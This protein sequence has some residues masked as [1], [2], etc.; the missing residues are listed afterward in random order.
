MQ[1]WFKDS[2]A[3]KNKLDTLVVP[4]RALLFSCDATSMYTNI[5]TDAAF[6]VIAAFLRQEDTQRKFEYNAEALIRALEIVMR[7]NIFRF[8]D[9]YIRQLSGTAMG[10]PCAPSWANIFQALWENQIVAL[11]AAFLPLYWRFLDDVLGLWIP[12]EDPAEDERKWQEFIALSQENYGLEWIFT[13]RGPSIDFMDLTITISGDRFKTSL[14]EKPMALYLYLPPHS[15]HAPGVR[16]GL[17]NGEIL[18][19]H[20][21]CTDED[22]IVARVRTFFRRMRRRGHQPRDILPLFKK[23][24]AN[25]LR[26][27]AT[28]E[29]D[30]LAQRAQAQTAA[31][32]RVYFHVEYHPQSPPAREV[33]HLFDLHVLNPPGKKPFN[34]LGPDSCPDIPL[35]AMIVA[36]HRSPNLGNMFSYRKLDKRDGPP[37]S[38][39]I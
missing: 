37:V 21:L 25:A 9:L 8:G 7:N 27:L 14:Y 5:D 30:R 26:F 15:C 24:R 19:I 3:L 22:D 18:R 28:S 34:L 32:R 33:Q 20:R 29:E 36:Y 10:K 17:I 4:H 2:F 23:G 39:F 38:S 12:H 1:T 11:Y 6:A 35:D 16:T 13:E 31:A